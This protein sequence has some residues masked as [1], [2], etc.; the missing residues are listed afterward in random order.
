MKTTLVQI[1]TLAAILSLLL[2]AFVPTPSQSHPVV[3]QYERQRPVGHK[4]PSCKSGFQFSFTTSKLTVFESREVVYELSEHA[5]CE[6]QVP[7]PPWGATWDTQPRDSNKS[8]FRYTL[9]V[10]DFAQ[11]R[12]FLD[13]PD[14]KST[15]SFLNAGPGV[16]DFKIIIRRTSGPQET[17]ALSLLPS[18]IQLIE[19]P[20][21]VHLVCRAKQMARVA[22]HAGEIPDWCEGLKPLTG[23]TLRE[24]N[25]PGLGLK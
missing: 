5:F 22:S 23:K 25:E 6:G 24:Q 13:R 1:K 9:T 4:D 20:A 15:E 2:S 11:F 3:T 8:V 17:E 7:D 10:S 12:S 19:H 16:G 14:V 21:L 18:H